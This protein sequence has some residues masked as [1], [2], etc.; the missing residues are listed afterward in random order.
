VPIGAV[1]GR[2]EVMDAAKPGTLGGTYG[3]NPIACA[4]ALATIGLIEKLQ[5]NRRAEVIGQR[6][7]ERLESLRPR[8]A[9]LADVRGIGAMIGAEFCHDGDPQRP[10][11]EFVSEIT[12]ACRERG[13]L[14]LPAGMHGN[15]LRF[16]APLVIEDADLDR[17]LQILTDVI[18][19]TR[20]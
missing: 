19:E 15:A 3:G 18:L 20:A 8:C 5:L 17:G 7:R 13:L 11:T 9:L 12:A 14:I 1:V 4:A 16:L 2:A 10:A 6:V